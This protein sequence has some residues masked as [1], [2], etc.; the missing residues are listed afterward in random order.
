MR[1][2][3]NSESRGRE[4]S[5]A[6]DLGGRRGIALGG[7]HEFESLLNGSPRVGSGVAGVRLHALEIVHSCHTHGSLSKN[8]PNSR[9]VTCCDKV[10]DAS[11]Y[12]E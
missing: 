7:V 2:R 8:S 12:S 10:G 6:R 4:S 3:G 5:W 9:R 1:I 11:I